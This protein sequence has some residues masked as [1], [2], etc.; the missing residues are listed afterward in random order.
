MPLQDLK[1]CKGFFY[2]GWAGQ[3]IKSSILVLRACA[4][5]CL[6]VQ[7]GLYLLSVMSVESFSDNRRSRLALDSGLFPV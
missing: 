2:L 6:F 3:L 1:S 7:A 5:A 4:I